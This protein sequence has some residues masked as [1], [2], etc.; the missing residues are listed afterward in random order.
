VRFLLLLIVLSLSSCYEVKRDCKAFKTGHFQSKIL[1]DDRV[2]ESTF[3]RYDNLQV[4]FFN[5]KIDSS[6]VRWINDCEMIFKTIN[7]KNRAEKKDIHIKILS[8][9]ETG[10]LFEYG[11][12][13]TTTKQKGVATCFLD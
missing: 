11:Y 6:S 8:T 10:Y 2:L 9:T 7:P 1:L 3:I 13:G 5:G 12:V 4:E